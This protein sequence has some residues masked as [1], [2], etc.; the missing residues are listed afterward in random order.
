MTKRTAIYC[1]I[2]DDR[3]GTEK[4][5]A[6]QELDCRDLVE[7]LG[8]EATEVFTDNDFSA[9]SGKPR[10]RYLAM[11]DQLKAG[12]FDA[13]VIYATDRLY[14]ST[15][16]LEDLIDLYE[17][18]PL[19]FKTVRSGDL[20]LGSPEGRSMARILV[21]ISR[22]ES[23]KTSSRLKRKNFEKAMNG[24]VGS[25]G[26]RPFG[27]Q[28]GSMLIEEREATALR[29]V[30]QRFLAGETIY[31]LCRWLNDQE[32]P[33]PAGRPFRPKA[34]RDIL[35]NP[36]I[37]GQRSYKGEIVAIAKWPGIITLEEGEAIRSIIK[38][39]KRL[40]APARTSL[41]IGLLVCGICGKK[42]VSHNREG[43][44]RY[45]CR[46][47][48]LMGLGCGG[49]YV[50][51]HPLE[52]FIVQAVLTRLNSPEMERSLTQAKPNPKALA[53]HAELSALDGRFIEL[54]EMV[55]EGEFTRIQYQAA[56]KVARERKSHLERTLATERGVVA[57]TGGLGSPQII[58]QKWESLNLDRQRAIMKSILEAVEVHKVV[59]MGM[60]FNPARLRPVW[61]F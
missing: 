44:R 46:K 25:T 24:E 40:E 8:W 42:L 60:P 21:S 2:S 49:I 20:D 27:Y 22:A 35:D 39:R 7:R 30:A 57:L 38:S 23:E 48:P 19:A 31:S 17:I 29:E 3:D 36:R 52:N 6:R 53:T 55:A 14:R 58:A 1:R 28:R 34:L 41:L 16:E 51:A 50:S 15:R 26:S 4:G 54:A 45:I 33:T 56:M 5:V 43:V 47:D 37:S 13:L 12:E 59:Q 32:V 18:R 9:Y 11:M 61:K 10:P